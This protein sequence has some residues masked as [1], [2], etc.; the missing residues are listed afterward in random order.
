MESRYTF[1][2]QIEL[3]FSFINTW[4][5]S[6]QENKKLL[7]KIFKIFIDIIGDQIT[8]N[9]LVDDQIHFLKE[10]SG[11]MYVLTQKNN[12]CAL[13]SSEFRYTPKIWIDRIKGNGLLKKYSIKIIDNICDFQNTIKP[14]NEI[15]V[16]NIYL[17]E[18]KHFVTF[19]LSLLI[20][21][22]KNILLIEKRIK[23]MKRTNE[24]LDLDVLLKIE[25]LLNK[26]ISIMKISINN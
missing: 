5:H 4:I 15:S 10:N 7:I 16:Q 25:I 22:E 12:C 20:V 23:Y 17:D 21:S 3:N 8:N 19:E 9:L 11:F 18:I 1:S 26:C 24:I 13:R 14:I 2:E 6:S